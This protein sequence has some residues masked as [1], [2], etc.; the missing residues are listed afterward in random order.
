[1]PE[2]IAVGTAAGALLV[3][4]GLLVR[5]LVSG[6]AST[7]ARYEAEINRLSEEKDKEIDRLRKD[8]EFWRNRALGNG[9]TT[10]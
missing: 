6:A 8:V 9:V 4:T 5:S 3:F 2:Q 7:A 10:T 1:M